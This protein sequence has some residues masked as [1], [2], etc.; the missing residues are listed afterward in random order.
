MRR[1]LYKAGETPRIF[2][3]EEEINSAENDGWKRRP[4]EEDFE[5]E[6]LE[7]LERDELFQVAKDEGLSPAHNIGKPSLILKIKEKREMQ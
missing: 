3:S 1:W 5:E 7:K 6:D 4:V 2:N